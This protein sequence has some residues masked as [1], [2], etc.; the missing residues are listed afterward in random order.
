MAP[1]FCILPEKYFVF[2]TPPKPFGEW[3]GDEI[4]YKERSHYVDVHIVRGPCPIIFQ[5]VMAPGFCISL[6]NTFVF[7]TPPKPIWGFDEICTKEDHNI[8]IYIM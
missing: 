3:V 4:W 5:G 7:V 2:A 8:E 1:G 6:E